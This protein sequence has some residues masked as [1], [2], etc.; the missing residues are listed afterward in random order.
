MIIVFLLLI[1]FGVLQLWLWRQQQQRTLSLQRVEAVQAR[2]EMVQRLRQHS[3]GKRFGRTINDLRFHIIGKQRSVA[4]Q[5]GMIILLAQ[6]AGVYLSQEYLH[7]NLQFTLPVIFVLTLYAL[8]LRRK[9][10]IRKEFETEFS[11][12]LNI[13][14]SSIRAGNSVIQGIEQC[15]QKMVGIVGEEFNQ[16]ALRLE[17]G[18]EP[19][20]VFMD[21]YARLPYREYYFFII[22]VLINMKGGGQVKE[23]MSRLSSLISN[24]RIIERKKFAMT[25]EVR[26]SIKIL[27]AIPIFFFYF[28]KFQSPASFDILLNHPIGQL[29]LYYS[30]SSILLGLLIVWMM[31]NKI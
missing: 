13:I 12:A 17:I 5:H 19:E 20:N 10:K 15:G 29:L 7:L 14:N 28:M 18:E 6:G 24:G 27:T 25:S 4:L 11:E 26:M 16:V 8:Y 23:V 3:L 21:S 31:M 30:I 1:L 2:N 9:K 22:A